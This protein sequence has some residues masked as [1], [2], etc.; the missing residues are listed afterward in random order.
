[1]LLIF[2]AVDFFSS[3]TKAAE[4]AQKMTENALKEVSETAIKMKDDVSR[5]GL[6]LHMCERVLRVCV[7]QPCCPISGY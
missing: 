5:I 3:V 2:V 4:A 1:V 6:G 7:V